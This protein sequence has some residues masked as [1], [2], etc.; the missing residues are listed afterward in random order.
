MAHRI[1]TFSTTLNDL[2]CRSPIAVFSKYDLS[3]NCTA[4]DD[5]IDRQRASRGPSA[6]DDLLYRHNTA[7]LCGDM[8]NKEFRYFLFPEPTAARI[9]RCSAS[10]VTLGG[11][12]SVYIWEVIVACPPPPHTRRQLREAKS[13]GCVHVDHWKKPPLS[14]HV[15]LST[16]DNGCSSWPEA[17]KQ[18][19]LRRPRRVRICKSI[20]GLR[21]FL[22]LTSKRRARASR[23]SACDAQ[24]LSDK[25]RAPSLGCYIF[26]CKL[27][28]EVLKSDDKSSRH[29]DDSVT[30]TS[31]RTQR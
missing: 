1:E 22:S 2:E 12:L 15:S 3:N 23:S 16:T 18:R 8:R 14:F 11:C 9:D 30:C 7:K 28:T 26:I 21:V 20:I 24:R 27:Q 10:T 31:C 17:E 19:P 25:T 5:H 6:T 13:S 29:R 4:F